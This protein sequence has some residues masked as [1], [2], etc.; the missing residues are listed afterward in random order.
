MQNKIL[1]FFYL[2]AWDGQQNRTFI[3]K[4][5][6]GG[7][8]YK[9]IIAVATVYIITV[10]TAIIILYQSH[11]SNVPSTHIYHKYIHMPIIS[12]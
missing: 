1:I 10:A 4:V 5:Y 2:H 9:I 8:I 11:I 3:A 7:Y 12:Q 6:D